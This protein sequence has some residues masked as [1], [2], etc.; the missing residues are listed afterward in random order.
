MAKGFLGT[1]SSETEENLWHTLNISALSSENIYESTFHGLILLR[2]CCNFRR[3][4]NCDPQLTAEHSQ[5]FSTEDLPKVP[6][7]TF[8]EGILV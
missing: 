7:P 2:L 5:L 1:A 4:R 6:F 3:A 8:R